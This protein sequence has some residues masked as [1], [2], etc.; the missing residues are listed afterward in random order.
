MKRLY[1]ST[2]WRKMRKRQLAKHPLCSMCLARGRH[3]IATVADH[4]I[5]HHEDVELF[6]DPDNLQS[7]CAI[8]HGEKRRKEHGGLY[9]GCDI[10]G[11]P[12]DN[13]HCWNKK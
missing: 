3:K 9:M 7:L 13:D 5:P 1:D 8:C 10:N 12:L 11:M 2:T 6:Y 4:K